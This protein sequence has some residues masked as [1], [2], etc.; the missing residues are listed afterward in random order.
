MDRSAL[1]QAVSGNLQMMDSF[2]VATLAAGRKVITA[3][4]VV[5]AAEVDKHNSLG[6]VG[7]E[8]EKLCRRHCVRR[9]VLGRR[10]GC[11][12]RGFN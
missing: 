10:I 11:V 6:T 4:L 2:W 5:V 7:K 9:S 8:I 1:S 12:P 3:Y